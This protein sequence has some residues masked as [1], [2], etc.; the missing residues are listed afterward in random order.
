LKP[1]PVTPASVS[2]DTCTNST[3][4]TLDWLSVIVRCPSG[5]STSTVFTAVISGKGRSSRAADRLGQLS[6][7]YTG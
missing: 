5:T 6:E 7:Q 2:I 4:S 3:E 1:W